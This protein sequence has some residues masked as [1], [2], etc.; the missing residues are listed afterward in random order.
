MGILMAWCQDVGNWTFSGTFFIDWIIMVN[1]L[2]LYHCQLDK[3]C[4]FC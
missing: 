1:F 3:D 2:P 4:G